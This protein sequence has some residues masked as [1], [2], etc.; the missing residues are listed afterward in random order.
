MLAADRLPEAVEEA[1]IAQRLDPFS[2]VIAARVAT[3]LYFAHRYREAAEQG[4][5]QFE[6]DPQ[7]FQGRAELGRAQVLLGRCPE[8]LAALE[9]SPEQLAAQTRGVLGFAYGRCG[10]RA[11]ALA[12]I[13]RLRAQSR[14]GVYASHYAIAVI[15]AS[16]GDKE[17]A[18]AELDRAYD[19]RAWALFTIKAEPAFE[20]LHGDPRFASLVA[21]V[22]LSPVGLE[23]K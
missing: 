15:Y 4:E 20:L 22:G 2:V 9:K 1:K 7:F 10:H 19:E 21:K 3:A 14:A 12:E 17:R 11:K 13:E 18:L 8:G 16:L 5:R 23:P 6:L